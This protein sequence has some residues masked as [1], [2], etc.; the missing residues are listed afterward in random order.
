ML[1]VA[2]IL[3]STCNSVFVGLD[4]MELS[5]AVSVVEA[6]VKVVLAPLLIVL[7][8]GVVGALVGHVVSYV[9]AGLLGVLVVYR[10]YREYSNPGLRF[11]FL[12]ICVLCLGLVFLFIFLLFC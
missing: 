12:G 10:V 9:V 3:F 11:D 6:V 1:I 7:G 5:A 2:Q 4:R 8:F